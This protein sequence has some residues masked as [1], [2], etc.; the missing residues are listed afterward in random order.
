MRV[1]VTGAAGA[2]GRYVVADLVRHG[3][4]VVAVDR[5][6]PGTADPGTGG[7]ADRAQAPELVAAMD[8]P[9]PDPSRVSWRIGDSRDEALM[10]GACA[11]ADALIH[12]A[13]IP[14]PVLGTPLEVFATNTQ[15]TFVALE[16][17]GVAGVGRVVIASSISLLGIPWSPTP[18]SPLYGPVDEEHPNIGSD[19]YALS[20]EV[21]EATLRTM[22]RRH[23]YQA[24]ALRISGT[25]PLAFHR[26]HA[27]A[28]AA[29]PGTRAHEL[30][31]Y[32]DTRDGARAFALAVE[33][34]IPGHH[35][36]NVMAPD[37]NS[38]LPSAE[39]M[40]RYH[41]TTPLRRPLIGRES[42]FDVTRC[43]ELLGFV[44]EH[45]LI[46]EDPA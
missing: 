14:A 3:H 22:H 44:P 27:P 36:I 43:R 4:E 41:P 38:P 23:G 1:V 42:I 11:G 35:V 32:L 16:A 26:H 2:I 31:A 46:Q 40:A 37:T 39:L 34:E 9:V 13:A 45:R 24:I 10:A 21:D 25:A 5:A 8:A 12:L 30:W 7:R 18:I 15:A 20:K 6:A 17:A 28:I 29:D 33:R 19:P